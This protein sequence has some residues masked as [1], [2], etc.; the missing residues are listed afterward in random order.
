M[1][2]WYFGYLSHLPEDASRLEEID[3]ITFTTYTA[4]GV[5]IDALAQFMLETL[6]PD[7]RRQNFNKALY[8]LGQ[9]GWEMVNA[10]ASNTR[11]W[12]KQPVAE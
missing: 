8:V 1:T 7:E 12:F 11:F 3:T 9:D 6:T 5:H 4:N 10:D 2:K